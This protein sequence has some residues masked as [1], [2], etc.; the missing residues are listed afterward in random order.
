M[1]SG[2]NRMEKY[3]K[4]SVSVRDALWTAARK[5]AEQEEIPMSRLV[6][7]ALKVYLYLADGG[8][9]AGPTQ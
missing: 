7:K 5:Q 4:H 1:T 2:S 6:S 8:P 3:G 9:D